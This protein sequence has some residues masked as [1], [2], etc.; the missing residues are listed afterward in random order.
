MFYIPV[1]DA[2]FPVGTRVRSRARPWWGI[3]TVIPSD[4]L[5][6]WRFRV[7]WADGA[8][9]TAQVH[10]LDLEEVTFNA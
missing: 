3:G 6:G 5:H 7:R 8:S 10:E 2:P 9:S 1:G 4:A